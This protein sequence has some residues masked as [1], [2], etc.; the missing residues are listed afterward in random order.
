ME[1]EIE[2]GQAK[3]GTQKRNGMREM[4]I[5]LLMTKAVWSTEPVF[6]SSEQKIHGDATCPNLG[7]QISNLL[8][9]C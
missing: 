1:I 3:K 9:D 7:G 4:E 6:S 2:K 8:D 5:P